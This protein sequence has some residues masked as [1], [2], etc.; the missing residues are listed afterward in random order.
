MT[1]PFLEEKESIKKYPAKIEG[2]NEKVWEICLK[3]SLDT[4]E[5]GFDQQKSEC[6]KFRYEIKRLSV[7]NQ[8][9]STNVVADVIFAQRT[10]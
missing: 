9:L 4:R 1:L 3:A 8:T 10:T 7:L 6:N 2:I 5:C